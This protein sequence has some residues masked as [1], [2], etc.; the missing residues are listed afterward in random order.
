MKPSEIIK[1][2]CMRKGVDPDKTL[3]ALQKL[4][5]KKH[6]ILLH[7]NNSVLGLVPIGDNAYETHLFTEDTPLKLSHSMLKFFHLIKDMKGVNT[8][9]GNADNASII[10]L[11]KTLAKKE[12]TTIE[13]PDKAGYNWMVSL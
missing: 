8:I 2:D 13:S 4:I 5:E 12:K 9:Y 10:N 7:Q 3:V 6:L 11:L 1:N